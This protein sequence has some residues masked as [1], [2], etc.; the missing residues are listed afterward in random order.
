MSP[1]KERKLL[2]VA[3]FFGA[4]SGKFLL[5]HKFLPLGYAVDELLSTKRN[6]V[7]VDQVIPLH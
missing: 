4:L 1:S 3:A 2:H 7:F 5:Q 6:A